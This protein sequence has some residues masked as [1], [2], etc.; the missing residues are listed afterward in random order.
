MIPLSEQDLAILAENFDWFAD[1]EPRPSA[2]ASLGFPQAGALHFFNRIDDNARN[3]PGSSYAL[4]PVGTDRLP[5]V[6]LVEVDSPR[7]EIARITQ[8]LM[9]HRTADPARLAEGAYFIA[10]SA[11]IGGNTTIAAGAVIEA[12]VEIGE[13]CLIGAGAVIKQRSRIDDRTIIQSGAVVGE[14]GYGFAKIDG[15]WSEPIAHMGGVEIGSNVTIGANAVICAGTIDPTIIGE[16]S[17]IDGLVYVGHNSNI[18]RSV[19]IIAQSVVGGS[20]T[21]GD[22]TWVNPGGLVK[23]KII[24]AENSVVGMGAVV[25]RSTEV[26]ETVIGNPADEVRKTMRREAGLISS[27]LQ[28][29]SKGIQ[30]RDQCERANRV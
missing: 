1:L 8:S 22:R 3:I 29:L 23:T 21:I 27:S 14:D 7:A 25:M 4:V 16:D 20:A 9:A 15:V 17:K 2:I 6:T 13:N 30:S 19:M 18:G 24:I 10:E 5:G 12:N 11:V 26:G 28:R